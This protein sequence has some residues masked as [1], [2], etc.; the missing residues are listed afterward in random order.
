LPYW[1]GTFAYF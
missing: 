1:Y